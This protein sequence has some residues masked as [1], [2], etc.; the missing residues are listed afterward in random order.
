VFRRPKIKTSALG[1]H[2]AVVQRSSSRV[3]VETWGTSVETQEPAPV[4][5]VNSF[6]LA[7]QAHCVASQ[8]PGGDPVSRQSW[9]ADNLQSQSTSLH[10]YLALLA[11]LAQL[12]SGQ[13]HCFSL[14]DGSQRTLLEAV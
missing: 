13:L 5:R 9:W 2:I 10:R 6:F 14:L 1:E 4:S 11:M 7:R 3:D 8:G 12:P